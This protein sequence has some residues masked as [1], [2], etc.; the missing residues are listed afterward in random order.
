MNRKIDILENVAVADQLDK[1]QINFQKT[2]AKGKKENLKNNPIFEKFYLL[3]TIIRWY[4]L[5]SKCR[6][7]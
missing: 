1:T 4:V 3:Y 6:K 7:M 2:A 5:K